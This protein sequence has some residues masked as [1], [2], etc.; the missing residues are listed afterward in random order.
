M[1]NCKNYMIKK[2]TIYGERCSGT[3]YL[4]NLV[5]DNFEIQLTWEYG[6]KHFFGF[7]DDMLKNSDD[8]LFLCIVRNPVDWI[9]SFF[10]N[11]HHLP[12][13]Y[14]HGLTEIE[15]L[16]EFLNKEFFSINDKENN[17][18]KWDKEKM[19]DRNIYTGERY[20]NI[21]E[22]R[23]TKIKW[24]L[25]E[26]PK[27]VKHYMFVKYE[28]LLNDFENILTQIKNKGLIIKS[29]INFPLNS[30]RYKDTNSK[31]E[32][33]MNTIPNTMIMNNSN[34]I[35]EYEEKLGYV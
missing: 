6:W 22:L 10:R 17:Y 14:K 4:Q 25:E 11:P 35:R 34:L 3:N 24:M 26:L 30:D 9:N 28:D 32:K 20:K 16:D 31:Y 13:N 5:N 1:L 19:E 27:K 7:Q 33:K 12:L 23:H 18:R 15:R 29:G 21:Y 2:F 8:T